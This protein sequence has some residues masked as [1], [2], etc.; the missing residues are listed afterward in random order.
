LY[1]PDGQKEYTSSV[2]NTPSISIVL[3]KSGTY[4]ILATTYSISEPTNYTL[5]LPC[6]TGECI[7]TLPPPGPA[8]DLLGYAPISPCRIVDTRLSPDGPI[9]KD[10]PT[11]DGDARAFL[12]SGTGAELSVQ[13]GSPDGCVHPKA[14]SGIEPAA[15]AAYVVAVP[16][17][18]SG[19]GNLLAFP[20]D[21]PDPLVTAGAILNFDAGQIIGNTTIITLCQHSDAVPCPD[22]GP[23]AILSRGT[24]Q[25]VVVDVQGYY[26][27]FQ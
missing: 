9:V 2:D 16:T 11:I 23:F 8:S 21:Q 4:S 22:E 1:D 6:I 27:P 14:D 18:Y 7:G 24:D 3:A 12:V 15:I 17:S 10:I 5:E 20:S 13:G 19:G 25:H 26:Y